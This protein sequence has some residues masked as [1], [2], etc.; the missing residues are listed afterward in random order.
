MSFTSEVKNQ[1]C[2]DEVDAN[3]SKAQLCALFQIRASLH[4][5]WQGMY[6]LFKVKM[7]RLPNTYFNF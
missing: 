2:K 4:M 7:R 6:C 5:N 1:I 3:A